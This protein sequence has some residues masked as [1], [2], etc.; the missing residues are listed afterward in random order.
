MANTGLKEVLVCGL[1]MT[2]IGR[3]S[4]YHIIIY[5]IT[6]IFFFVFYRNVSEPMKRSDSRLT[7]IDC[8][9]EAAIT[10]LEILKQN[11]DWFLRFV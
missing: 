1:G 8:E 10:A 7:N 5:I 6:I 2:M 3:L 11:G 4:I 9:I